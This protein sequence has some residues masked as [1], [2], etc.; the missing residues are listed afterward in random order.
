MAPDT[1]LLESLRTLAGSR[2]VILGIGNTL[3]GDDGVG[4]II[5]ERLADCVSA[6]VIDAGTVPENHIARIAR[7][8]PDNLLV[9]D[10]MDS[11]ADPG[12]IRLFDPSDIPSV[13]LSTHTLSPRLFIDLIQR[14]AEVTVRFLGIQPSHTQFAAP[15][16]EAVQGAVEVLVDLLGQV[17][18]RAS[19]QPEA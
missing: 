13:A 6:Q 8:K 5:C 12:T 19:E 18:P 3:K 17:F 11:G 10:A 2:T 9:I 1:H 4:P 7:L 14:E 15:L 16:S